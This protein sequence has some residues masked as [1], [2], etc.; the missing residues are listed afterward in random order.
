MTHGRGQLIIASKRIVPFSLR[1]DRAR[2]VHVRAYI[3]E[4]SG[5]SRCARD[6]TAPR[7][8]N[9]NRILARDSHDQRR[10]ADSCETPFLIVAATAA[11]AA[12]AAA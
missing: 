6:S 1:I 10:A 12:A 4:K 8:R 5:K 3:Y 11:A 2:N 7:G 9:E